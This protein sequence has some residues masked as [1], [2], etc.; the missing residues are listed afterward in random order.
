MANQAV[1]VTDLSFG[2][3][4]K[5]STTDYLVRQADSA[6]VVMHTGGAQ[7]AHNVITPEGLHHKFAQF[8]SGSLVDGV[9]THIG[10]QFL[11]NPVSMLDEGK[12]LV[13]ELGVENVWER[14][15]VDKNA[16]I[17]TPWQIAANKLRELARGS[18]R[19]GSCGRGI[20]ETQADCLRDPDVAVR[21]GDLLNPQLLWRKLEQMRE[22]KYNQL[23]DEIGKSKLKNW[24]IFDDSSVLSG[25]FDLYQK[26]V[27]LVEIVGSDYLQLL[28]LQHELMV[29]EGAQGVLLDEWFGFHPYT[30][31]STTTHENALALLDGIDFNGEVVKLGIMRAYT[32]RHGPG[33]FVTEDE[34]MTVT[35]P[36]YH[37]D[38]G[39][40]Q[41]GFRV[42][43]L[44]LVAHRY[45]LDVCGETDGLVVSCLDRLADQNEWKFCREYWLDGRY[46]D[47]HQYF[48]FN[49]SGLVTSIKVG[50]KDDLDYQTR[51]TELLSMCHPVYGSQ[52]V[53]NC[54]DPKEFLEVVEDHLGLPIRIASFGP[55]AADKRTLAFA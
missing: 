29:F 34:K 42:G 33:P 28:N 39:K 36:D 3:A 55:T 23:L 49:S 13:E 53:A 1:V 40:W 30:T 47:A 2:D 43:H 54:S 10:P 31:W 21:A 6:V 7:R 51:L 18:N 24:G 5:G 48:E 35:T 12:H 4:S 15:T 8:G 19:H 22:M 9:R 45:A 25:T 20:G 32:T 38:T 27:E 17:I 52:S 26:W 14:V 46:D 41:G 16:L 44:D 37:N 50:V 11:I